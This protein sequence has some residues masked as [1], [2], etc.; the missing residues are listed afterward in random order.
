[1]VTNTINNYPYF[2]LVKNNKYLFVLL[3]LIGL[4]SCKQQAIVKGTI[5]GAGNEQLYILS[6]LQ[7]Q[8]I[9][10]ITLQD[11]KFEYTLKTPEVSILQIALKSSGEANL[12]FAEPGTTTIAAAK[13]NLSNWQVSGSKSNNEFTQYINELSPIQSKLEQLQQN[14]EHV[15]TPEQEASFTAAMDSI[16]MQK[17]SITHAFVSKH[18]NSAVAAYL[19]LQ[20]I[21]DA[22]NEAKLA[23]YFT[24]LS[25]QARKT[26][27]GQVITQL[28]YKLKAI[29][30]GQPA[31]DITSQ[32]ANGNTVKLS[33]YRGQVVLVDFW[34]SW[35]GPCRAENPNVVKAYN[36]FKQKGFTILGVSLDE[37]KDAWQNAVQ[38]D[39]LAWPQVCD[40]A[41]WEGTAPASYGITS[42]PSNILVDKDGKIIAKNLRGEELIVA[43]SKVFN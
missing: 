22:S 1:L 9:D 4:A 19:A 14:A 15:T 12:V 18:N 11:G 13:G 20:D 35:C 28:Y 38:K 42:I 27:Y 3:V 30:V 10:S 39:G 33:Q 7:F 24:T 8:Q 29:S 32:D 5:T 21:G 23:Q 43:L 17:S 26:S 36:M 25:A 2:Y 34:A 41:G 37:S 16:M 31:I 6:G 40:F